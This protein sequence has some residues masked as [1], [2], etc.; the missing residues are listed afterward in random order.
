M[1]TLTLA[2]LVG[3]LST[4]LM[5]LVKL[6]NVTG[7]LIVGL[8][9]GPYCLKIITKEEIEGLSLLIDIALGFIAFSIGGEFKIENLKKIGKSV[10][11]ITFVQSFLALLFVDISLIIVCSINKTLS[12]NLPMIL[13]LGAIATA[14][15]PA[16][17]LMVIRQ[18]KACGKVTDTLLLVVALDD[19]FG[20]ILFAI[21]FAISKVF[22][23]GETISAST[24]LFKP[25]LEIVCA[26]GIGSVLGLILSIAV[27]FFKSRAN[28]LIWMITV[29]FA[30]VAICEILAKNGIETSSLLL[31]MMT[32]AV[33]CNLTQDSLTIMD[34]CERWTP[35]LFMLFF[36]ISSAE[37]DLSVIPT[38]GI[39]GIVYLIARSLGKYFGAFLGA[40]ISKE[41]KKVRNYLGLALLPQAGVAI[42]MAKL[43]S[44]GLPDYS[45]RILAVVLC[46]TLVYELIGPVVTKYALSKSGE[47]VIEKKS[48][49]KNSASNAGLSVSNATNNNINNI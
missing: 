19:A 18:Y 39:I 2:L 36:I 10:V 9:I 1:L 7:Y 34:G 3:L 22:A 12:E 13:V 42:G 26:L 24:V 25:L 40:V 16:A 46:A 37:L 44:E 47:I 38:V 14:T 4:R 6:P 49:V 20:L 45:S 48:K 29:V 31:C 33:F 41:D 21:S 43:A 5:K 35:P 8:I 17:T 23:N 28:R 15:A 27:K 11:F 32:G 30:G